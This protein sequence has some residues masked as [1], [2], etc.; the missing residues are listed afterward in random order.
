MCISSRTTRL[1]VQSCRDD[2][3]CDAILRLV[4]YV[5]YVQ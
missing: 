5:K 2:K 4:K 3:H 1:C